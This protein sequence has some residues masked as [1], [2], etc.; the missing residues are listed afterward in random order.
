[1]LE[2][3]RIDIACRGELKLVLVVAHTRTAWILYTKSQSQSQQRDKQRV[4][5]SLTVIL[6]RGDRRFGF[7]S[8]SCSCSSI[9]LL[10]SFFFLRVLSSLAAMY[11]NMAHTKHSRKISKGE[12]RSA[13]SR[14][15]AMSRQPSRYLYTRILYCARIC[16]CAVH[17]APR[18][19]EFANAHAPK[20][21][22]QSR[23]RAVA[24]LVFF[25]SFFLFSLLVN[26]PETC[27]CSLQ[28]ES[29]A[30]VK[31]HKAT[32]ANST[33]DAAGISTGGNDTRDDPSL[34][35][36]ELAFFQRISTCLRNFS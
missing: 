24:L 11:Y 32:D 4:N 7:P 12:P 6:Q 36:T 3:A 9:L 14:Y 2:E 25:F 34:Q 30:L 28:A 5:I 23:V 22:P 1:M 21:P 27:I 17:Y 29:D 10:V 13:R 15:T 16:H 26:G 20:S 35:I 8:S 18:G 31:K 19:E 33:N